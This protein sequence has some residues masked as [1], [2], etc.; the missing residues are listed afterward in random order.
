MPELLQK[1]FDKLGKKL[2][3]SVNAHLAAFE[4]RM[5]EKFVKL[6]VKI[7]EE[8]KKMEDSVEQTEDVIQI[9]DKVEIFKSKAE[10]I[11][12]SSICFYFCLLPGVVQYGQFYKLNQ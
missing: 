6:K 8:I 7:K 2:F 11:N 10:V 5:K 1:M 12:L 3:E 9:N 4:E